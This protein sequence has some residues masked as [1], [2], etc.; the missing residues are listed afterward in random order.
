MTAKFADLIASKGKNKMI[1]SSVEV[2]HVYK[3]PLT[4][5]EGIIPKYAGESFRNKYF[6]VLA[7][8][9]THAIGF[10]VINT[11]I[12]SNVSQEIKDLYY[13]LS[14]AKYPFL[15]KNRYVNCSDLMPIEKDKFTK[16]FESPYA[17]I[18]SEDLELI[19]QTVKTAPTISPKILKR[20][21]LN[22]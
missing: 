14:A 22:S 2:G 11:N 3:M 4:E 18:D 7:L 17:K 21:K 6:I 8:D 1:I 19:I 5:K 15:E 16:F 20:F 9:E 13:P 10:V 12:N